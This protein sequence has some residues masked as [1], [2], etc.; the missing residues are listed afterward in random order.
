[1]GKGLE[2]DF[3]TADRI[4]LLNLKD[5]RMY[6]KKELKEHTEGKWLH[7]EDVV[8]N[9][10]IITALNLLIPYYGGTND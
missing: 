4:T 5:Q 8:R 9:A 10:E 1:M 6:L 2:I 3:D 7:P